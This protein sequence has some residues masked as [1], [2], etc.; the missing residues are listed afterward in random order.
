MVSPMPSM[1]KPAINF[2][3]LT[4][5]DFSIA[6]KTFFAPREILSFSMLSSFKKCLVKVSSVNL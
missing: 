5:L 4:F 6:C 3:R 2:E 1:S